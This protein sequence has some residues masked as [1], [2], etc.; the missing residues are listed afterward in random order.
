MLYLLYETPVG[1]M[2]FKKKKFDE[3]ALDSKQIMKAVKSLE[4][5]SKMVK[6]QVYLSP[7]EGYF[8]LPRQ[9]HLT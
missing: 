7:N 1:V 9:R 2:L 3:V 8:P 6:L 4:T 5:F